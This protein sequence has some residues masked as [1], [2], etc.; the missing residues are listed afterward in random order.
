MKVKI[1]D[2]CSRYHSISST[3]WYVVMTL[4]ILHRREVFCYAGQ[5]K[6]CMR[7]FLRVLYVVIL[8]WKVIVKG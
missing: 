6:I 7:L 8:P 4:L 1:K 3:G 2:E 5:N